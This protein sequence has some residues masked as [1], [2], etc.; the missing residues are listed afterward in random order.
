MFCSDNWLSSVLIQSFSLG[1]VLYIR[2]EV[3]VAQ[4][5]FLVTC[6]WTKN[7]SLD[8]VAVSLLIFFSVFKFKSDFGRSFF[9]LKVDFGI[10][11]KYFSFEG[12]VQGVLSLVNLSEQ[13][14]FDNMEE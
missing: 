2:S 3:T 7:D 8:S 13:S 6:G 11:F 5:S 4:Y 14:E 9:F 12:F 1:V 10:T